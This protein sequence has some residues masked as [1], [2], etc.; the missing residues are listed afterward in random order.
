MKTDSARA[1][2]SAGKRSPISEVAAGAQA[3]SPTPTPRRSAKSCQKL[4]ARPES[5]VSRLQAKTPAERIRVR[6]ARSLS[7]P[8]GTP[9]NA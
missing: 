4:R 3:A 8:S 6:D 7:R 1:R 2:C 5:P 9:A